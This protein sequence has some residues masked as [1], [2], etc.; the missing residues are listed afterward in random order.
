MAT[1][2]KTTW[3]VT[4]NG[5]EVCC[6]YWPIEA[7]TSTIRL[8]IPLANPEHANGKDCYDYL[9][10]TRQD[11]SYWVEYTGPEYGCPTEHYTE[12][13]GQKHGA[14]V[15]FEVCWDGDWVYGKPVNSPFSL[16]DDANLE[17]LCEQSE[18]ES[19]PG[20]FFTVLKKEVAQ[21]ILDSLQPQLEQSNDL[22]TL[23]LLE[24]KRVPEGIKK[25]D[26][27]PFIEA[28]LRWLDAEQSAAL[29]ADAT[30]RSFSLFNEQVQ[31]FRDYERLTGQKWG[32]E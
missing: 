30:V 23:A 12:K 9:D 15:G 10:G 5:I 3:D 21:A 20:S 26:H 1:E 19:Y 7:N 32:K 13:G 22:K 18:S 2:K 28:V 11:A 16:T 25:E 24:S 27:L 31:Y 4:V 29:D 8:R 6:E 14:T 17:L